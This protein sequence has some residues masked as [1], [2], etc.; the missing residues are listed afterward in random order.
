M[1]TFIEFIFAAK[2]FASPVIIGTVVGVILMLNFAGNAG[3]ALM[4]GSILLGIA[5]GFMILYR[6]K[7]NQDYS[8]FDARVSASPDID[9]A[10][11]DKQ[12]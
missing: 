4:A 10:I 12:L 3:T 2:I 1:K 5:V 6:I 8:D 7:K 11:A 9:K